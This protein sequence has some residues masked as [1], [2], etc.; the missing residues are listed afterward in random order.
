MFHHV[1]VQKKLTQTCSL[2]AIRLGIHP[3]SMRL[4]RKVAKLICLLTKKSRVWTIVSYS[5]SKT[6]FPE[7]RYPITLVQTIAQ[8]P[9]AVVLLFKLPLYES[10]ES[11]AREGPVFFQRSRCVFPSVSKVPG[12]FSDLCKIVIFHHIWVKKTFMSQTLWPLRTQLIFH[13]NL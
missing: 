10:Y 8:F 4:R 2:S 3:Q 13:E 1:W 5:S 6:W 7:A 11:F 9:R 12:E